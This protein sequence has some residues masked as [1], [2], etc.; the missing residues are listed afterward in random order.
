MNHVHIDSIHTL[1]NHDEFYSG[2]LPEVYEAYAEIFGDDDTYRVEVNEIPRNDFNFLL[3]VL[4]AA[5]HPEDGP[6]RWV[7]DNRQ[8]LFVRGNGYSWDYIRP[9]FEAAG[10]NP[11]SGGRSLPTDAE[12]R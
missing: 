5:G 1:R 6:L 4:G 3:V 12:V 9:A 10:W 8:E 7:C 2:K 11:P